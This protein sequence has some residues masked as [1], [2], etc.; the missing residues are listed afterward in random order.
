MTFF[1]GVS[2]GAIR[3]HKLL[4]VAALALCAVAGFVP[5]AYGFGSHSAAGQAP[6]QLGAK[7]TTI[8]VTM[9]KPTEFHFTLSKSKNIP[10]GT[11]VFKLVNKGKVAHDFKIN[12]KTSKLIKP[13]KTGT[14][15]VVFKKKGSYTYQCTVP[16]HAKLGM[17]GALG[18]ATAK[19]TPPPPPATTTTAPPPATTTTASAA[20]TTN[21]ATTV[22]VK[23]FEFGFTLSQLSIPCGT[24]TF[25][26][27]NTGSAEHNFDLQGVSAN[28]VGP[29]VEPGQSETQVVTFTQSGSYGYVCDVPGHARL[30]MIGS[31]TVTP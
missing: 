13:G 19:V 16:G 1:N 11:V 15:T 31:L 7:K 12:G 10:V 8:T 14:L 4:A 27:T 22:Q 2:F 17:K 24:V 21:V 6:E 3:S 18:I 28:G 9:G 26:V 30:G 23:M 29:L 25:V 20:C 5:V